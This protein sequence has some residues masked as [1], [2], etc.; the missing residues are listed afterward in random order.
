[1]QYIRIG[2]DPLYICV[3]VYTSRAF[4]IAPAF[5]KCFAIQCSVLR[6]IHIVLFSYSLIPISGVLRVPLSG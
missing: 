5:A 4:L 6:G 1:M 2:S 3:S